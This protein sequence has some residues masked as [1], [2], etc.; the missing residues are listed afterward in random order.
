MLS[1]ATRAH[2]PPPG[3]LSPLLERRLGHLLHLPRLALRVGRGRENRWDYLLGYAPTSEVVAVEPHSAKEDHISTVIK[4]RGAAREQLK[5]HLR[6]GARIA[7]WLWGASGDVH[8]TDTERARRWLDQNGI[9]FVG[10]KVMAKQLPQSAAGRPVA[11]KKRR[12]KVGR[13]R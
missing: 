11:K 7:R 1:G 2:A 12:R 8:F 3:P 5:M 4:K 10:K 9:E 13:S 6:D